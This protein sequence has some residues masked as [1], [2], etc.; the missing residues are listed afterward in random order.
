MDFDPLI[1]ELITTRNQFAVE[2]LKTPREQTE[3][4]FGRCSGFIQGIEF[5]LSKVNQLLA[6]EES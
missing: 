2:S 4:E 3:F 5:A 6:Q 1:R